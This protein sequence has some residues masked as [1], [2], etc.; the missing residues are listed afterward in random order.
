MEII[1][2]FIMQNKMNSKVYFKVNMLEKDVSLSS[3]MGSPVKLGNESSLKSTS[4]RNAT[5]LDLHYR[6]EQSTLK[7]YDFQYFEIELK[8]IKIN[9]E[10]FNLLD[11]RNVTNIIKNQQKL[12]DTMYQDAIEANYSHEQMTPLNSILGNS[13]IVLRRFVEL[14]QKLIEYD[15]TWEGNQKNEETLKLLCAIS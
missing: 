13:K 3:F 7:K 1:E 14:H 2:N 8:F 10:A 9:E 5:H 15:G 11:I 4:K 12:S 6:H